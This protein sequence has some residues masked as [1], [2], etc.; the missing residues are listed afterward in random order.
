MYRYPQ[1]QEGKQMTAYPWIIVR[2]DRFNLSAYGSFASERDAI[3]ALWREAL[4][5]GYRPEEDE[6][7]SDYYLFTDDVWVVQYDPTNAYG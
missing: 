6:T 5:S 2:T 3:E 7:A 4:D 1:P